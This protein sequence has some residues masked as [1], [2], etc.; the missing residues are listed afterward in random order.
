MN[1][2]VTSISF[3]A[4]L[5]LQPSMVAAYDGGTVTG[6]VQ[7]ECQR[8][9]AFVHITLNNHRRIGRVLIEVKNA[10]GKVLYRE[11]GKAMDDVLVRRLDKGVFPKGE[12]TLS[13]VSRDFASTQLFSVQ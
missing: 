5:A 2:L 12:L 6:K 7:V 10:D 3:V 1:I 4:L 9:S 13:V 8:N 11:Q